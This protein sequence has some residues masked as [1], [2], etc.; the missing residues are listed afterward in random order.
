L[1]EFSGIFTTNNIP[2]MTSLNTS[3]FGG[4]IIGLATAYLYNKFKAIQLP[5]TL[6]FFSGVRF[7]P[8]ISICCAMLLGI[9]FSIT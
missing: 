9:L 5:K 8:I 3:V 1:Q 4:I 2:G 6:G 7:I